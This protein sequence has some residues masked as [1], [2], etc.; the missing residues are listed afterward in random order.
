MISRKERK[1]QASRKRAEIEEQIR[2]VMS[3]AFDKYGGNLELE[4]TD[5]THKR[6]K[7]MLKEADRFIIGKIKNN[8]QEAHMYKSAAHKIGRE[9]Q[10]TI[11]I[12]KEVNH[13]KYNTPRTYR[14]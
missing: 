7:H 4:D 11:D 3:E 9:I 10:E 13:E 5:T 1:E 8:P 6:F 14:N 12:W 2:K